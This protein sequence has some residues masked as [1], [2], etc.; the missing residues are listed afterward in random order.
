MEREVQLGAGMVGRVGERKRWRC[1]VSWGRGKQVLIGASDV[2]CVWRISL[3]MVTK[4][5]EFC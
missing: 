2:G 4:Y 1:R 3:D 5:L